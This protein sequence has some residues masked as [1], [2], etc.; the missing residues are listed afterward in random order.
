MAEMKLAD[1]A[2]GI[3]NHLKRFEADKAINRPSMARGMCCAFCLPY[4]GARAWASGSRIGVCYVSY[5]GES[6]L[7]KA[8]AILYL[9]RLDH[10]FVG[11]HWKAL[12]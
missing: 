1:I 6:Y 9:D 8:E 2:R 7:T 5:Q 3:D 12:H 10:G 4:Y 11:K